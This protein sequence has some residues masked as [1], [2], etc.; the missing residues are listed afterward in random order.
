MIDIKIE[1]KIGFIP[2]K[3]TRDQAKDTGM[4]MVL[5]FLLIGSL[6]EKHI[7]ISLAIPLLLIDMILPD[8]YRPVAKIWF[9]LSHLMGTLMSKLILTILFFII[10]TPVGLIRRLSGADPLQINKW[11]KNHSTV[12]R[13][14]D[15]KFS[16]EDIKA[17]Y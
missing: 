5:I 13:V 12:F 11:K 6:G 16:S 17:P 7:F 4:A 1:K 14:R 8:V 3:I 10:V 15:H 2:D 9:G